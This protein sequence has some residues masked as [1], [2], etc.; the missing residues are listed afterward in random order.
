MPLFLKLYIELNPYTADINEC[1]FDPCENNGTCINSNGSYTC[2]CTDGWKDIN[3]LQGN[4]VIIM[5]FVSNAMPFPHI[6][7]AMNWRRRRLS[8][9]MC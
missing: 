3:C 8:S 1:D 6:S 5:P 7:I 9:V 2:N 4:P